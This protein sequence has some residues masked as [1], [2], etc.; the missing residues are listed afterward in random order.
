MS[1][2]ALRESSHERLQTPRTKPRDASGR[3]RRSNITDEETSGGNSILK[4][5]KA[6]LNWLTPNSKSDATETDDVTET[7]SS[8]DIEEEI[9]SDS[10]SFDEQT[11]SSR[12]DTEIDLA[13]VFQESFTTDVQN[14]ENVES[15]GSNVA[16]PRLCSYEIPKNFEPCD[17]INYV[18]RNL[19]MFADDNEEHYAA[20]M[21]RTTCAQLKNA[22]FH[23][24]FILLCRILSVK[25]SMG[26][27]TYMCS[28]C[29]QIKQI[30][31]LKSGKKGLRCCTKRGKADKPK[32][33][34]YFILRV[35]DHTMEEVNLIVQGTQAFHFCANQ[36]RGQSDS[37]FTSLVG[38][39]VELRVKVVLPE[40]ENNMEI[41]YY[42]AHSHLNIEAWKACNQLKDV[43]VDQDTSLDDN[44]L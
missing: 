39:L 17:N 31:N 9:Q 10:A 19:M 1:V 36:M 38:S 15:S 40:D 5:V 41:K 16:R 2:T 28:K 44:N 20:Q 25:F 4:S 37:F 42:V 27:H 32:K 43:T 14:D 26:E 13:E 3:F 11:K 24:E 30:K 6:V 8:A 33:I 29:G 34:M 23:S 18:R 35:R 12:P 7:V 22:T 21:S